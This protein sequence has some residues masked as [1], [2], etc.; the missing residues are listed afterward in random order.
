MGL[1]M[2]PAL[3]SG[4]RDQECAALL[5]ARITDAEVFLLDERRPIGRRV[6][7]HGLEVGD[8]DDGHAAANTSGVN[9]APTKAA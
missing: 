3:C 8:A 9:V 1:V 4:E 2:L 7:E 5:G 6:G